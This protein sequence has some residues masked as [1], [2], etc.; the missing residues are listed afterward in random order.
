MD[1]RDK[2]GCVKCSFKVEKVFQ[3]AQKSE[4]YIELY[5]KL[6]EKIRRAR[7]KE[8]WVNFNWLSARPSF[9]LRS[10]CI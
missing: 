5:I 6:W 9:V 10:L 1:G 4:K 2:S 8:Y 3:N 7:A